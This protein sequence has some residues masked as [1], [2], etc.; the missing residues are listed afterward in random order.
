MTPSEIIHFEAVGAI[1]PYSGSVALNGIC[2]AA[3]KIGVR[4]EGFE[5]EVET[6]I[7]AVEAELARSG[8]DLSDVISA[9][10]YLTDMQRYAEFNE[11]YAR[12]LPAPYPART[13]VA[14]RELPA[15]AAVEIQVVA[16]AP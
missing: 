8:M 4:G 15:G 11:I 7:D 16:S 14:V 2:F 6:A 12:R 13:C 10:V 9:T 5:R 1:G 3:G